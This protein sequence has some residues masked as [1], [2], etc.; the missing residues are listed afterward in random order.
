M[1]KCVDKELRKKIFYD[2][3][4]IA[5]FAI[6][7]SIPMFGINR[8][9]FNNWLQSEQMNSIEIY[10]LFSGGAFK[11]MSFFALGV[12]PYITASIIVQ[13]LTIIIPR[14]EDLR[15]QS[16]EKIEKCTY[17]IAVVFTLIQ[18][19]LTSWYFYQ[20]DL[21]QEKSMFFV[22][23]VFVEMCSGALC[24][25]LMAKF[26]DKHGIGKGISL[27]LLTNIV[28][29]LPLSIK[30]LYTAFVP[31]KT[32][33]F[34]WGATTVIVFSLLLIGVICLQNAEKRIPIQ[35]AGQTRACG[36]INYLPIKLNLGNIMPVVFTSSIFQAILLISGLTN[37]SR[38]D[39]FAQFFNMNN[40]FSTRHPIYM[41]GIIPYVALV[42]LFSYFYTAFSFDTEQISDNLK[43]Q[44]IVIIGIRP[45]EAT[46]NYLKRQLRYFIFLGAALLIIIVLL[47]TAIIQ[48]LNI[49]NFALVGTS[50]L[51]LSSVSVELFKEIESEIITKK[52]VNFFA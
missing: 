16:Q 6:G 11:S 14:L 27:I 25:I 12:A 32:N 38:F 52:E 47:P 36:Q 35:H 49:S 48:L 43:K 44:N 18:A 29:Q 33:I 1:L 2:I 22:L 30:S 37:S 51:I 40:W 28:S 3:V 9:Y 45:G 46:A 20:T 7:S 31:D 5:L 21:L 42:V 8:E 23:I 19:G 34:V 10:N 17:A 41:L 39:Y 50:F 15:K 13:L 26:L 4:I 24:V